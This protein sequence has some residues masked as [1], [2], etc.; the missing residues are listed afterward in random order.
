MEPEL[1]SAPTKASRDG[2]VTS[3][4]V[5]VGGPKVPAVDAGIEV[6]GLMGDGRDGEDGR[7]LILLNSCDA[8]I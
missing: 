5:E 4:F 6:V 8:S 1:L 2:D 7:L 3:W